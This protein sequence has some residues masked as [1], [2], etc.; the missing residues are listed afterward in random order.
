MNK[1]IVLTGDR[2]TGPLHLGHFVG[3]LKKRLELQKK[4]DCY[5]IIADYQVLTD[6][7][8]KSK[9][10]RHYIK[11]IVLDYLSVGI[12]PKKSTIF[13][14]SQIPEIAELNLILS[15]MVTLARVQRNPTVKEEI[16]S[17]GIKKASL[18]FISYPVSQAADI[19]CVK[20]NLVPVGKDQ[21][22]HIELT[23]E[24]AYN[25]NRIFGETFPIPKAVLSSTQILPGLDGQKMS[26]SRNNA[27]FLSDSA[28]ILEKKVMQAIT[29][30]Q[31]IR[32]ND[33]G[34]PEICNVYRYYK[35]F[36]PEKYIEIKKDCEKGKI[37]CVFCKKQLSKYLNEFLKP[38]QEKRNYFS[39]KPKII[40]EILEEGRIKTQKK[41][42]KTLEEVKEKI[43]FLKNESKTKI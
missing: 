28:K 12:N 6:Q 29:D 21:L 7:L 2:P 38:I 40:K 30:P 17:S 16:K 41:V 5:F 32:L 33:P 11:E 37:G 19:L 3:S 9:N 23:R 10:I 39:K 25:F 26:K 1:K 13:V 15:M 27:I 4:Y 8:E 22:P 42:Q 14:Q 43:G 35:A 31:K 20:A 36:F 18:G 24:I 34:H